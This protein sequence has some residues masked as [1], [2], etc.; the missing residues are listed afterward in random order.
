MLVGKKLCK[1]NYTNK[2]FSS[3]LLQISIQHYIAM[4]LCCLCL[5]NSENITKIFEDSKEYVASILAKHFWFEPRKD[6]PAFSAICNPCWGKLYDFHEFYEMVEV[7]HR[8]FAEP[9][10][11]TVKSEDCGLLEGKDE[12]T[13]EFDVL[14]EVPL[15]TELMEANK[16]VVKESPNEACN[17]DDGDDDNTCDM[18]D[19]FH[20][21]DEH[22][23]PFD[24]TECLKSP[25]HGHTD[26]QTKNNEKFRKSIRSRRTKSSDKIA[27]TDSEEAKP[28]KRGRKRKVEN[29]PESE[30]DETKPVKPRNAKAKT[31]KK[32][33]EE[34]A[35]KMKMKSF[36][37]EISQYMGLHCDLCNVAVDN[38]AGIKSHMRIEHNIENGYVKCCDKKFNKRA[39]LLAHIRH[40]V[41]PNC[42]RCDECNQI[43]SDYQSLRNHNFIKHQKEEDK[44]FLCNECP[45]KF[46]KKY[47]LEQ[48]RTFKHKDRFKQCKT[49]NRRYKTLAELEE[50]NKEPCEGGR[51]CDICAK[52]IFGPSAFKRHQLEHEEGRAREQCDL[53]G[54]WHKD[55][56]ALRKHKRRH[57]QPKTPHVCDICNKVS[58]SRDAMESHKKYAHRSERTFECEFC[59]K[60]FKRPRS[61]REHLSTHTGAALYTCPHCPKTFNSNANMHSHR[62]NV[63]PVEFEEARKKRQRVGYLGDQI[64]SEPLTLKT[65]GSKT[66]TDVAN[67][68]QNCKMNDLTNIN[69]EIDNITD[70]INVPSEQMSIYNNVN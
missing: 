19:D 58:P 66:E 60:R 4:I 41:D 47:L 32:S 64:K 37:D 8:R 51:M 67:T 27:P 20:N 26:G 69:T 44:V 18:G 34:S 56:Y 57:M 45:K 2:I 54:S 15:S 55:K 30:C 29:T 50:H 53:C 35:Y 62:K 17:N 68:K 52:V 39:N 24:E 1:T 43:F 38:F 13:D 49:C 46:A 12:P 33:D 22:S 5:Q 21:Y 25:S 7:V 48:H 42:Y 63:H 16:H 36:D 40:H 11:V 23:D 6:D 31:I 59:K 61:L 14:R 65:E 3:I 70:K 28:K 9:E 10:I